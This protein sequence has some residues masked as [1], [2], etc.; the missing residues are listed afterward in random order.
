[1]SDRI[2]VSATERGQVRVFA[3]DMAP[4]E[5]RA[6][7]EAPDLPFGWPLLDALGA[8]GL[9]PEWIDLV[10]PSD[11]GEM[12]LSEFL[13]EGPGVAPEALNGDRARLDGLTQPVLV[14]PSQ[15]F[16]GEEQ[17]LRP[18]APLRWIGTYAELRPAP[19]GP[20]LRSSAARGQL[21]PKGGDTGLGAAVRAGSFVVT[22][23]IALG[24]LILII[25]AVGGF[26]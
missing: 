19:P 23:M 13:V 17:D 8:E 20:P 3:L 25:S 26:R 2:H 15:A 5:A 6:F 12:S 18:R 24:V 10:V 7:A 16:G 9:D 22:A 14:L 1:M 4:K 11:L 21:S